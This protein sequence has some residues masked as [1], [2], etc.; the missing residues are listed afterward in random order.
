MN[1]G[2]FPRYDMNKINMNR[3]VRQIE[4]D[5][6]K[7]LKAYHDT[8]GLLTV[9]IGHLIKKTDPPAICEL[10]LGDAITEDQCRELL[11]NDLAIAISDF[12][13]IF[14]NW[15]TMPAEAQEILI[16]MLFN[17]GRDR[18]LKF[19]KLIAAVYASDWKE[20]AIQMEDSRWYRQVGT[21][22]KRLVSRMRTIDD[23]ASGA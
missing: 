1:K 22:A 11:N 19:K 7:K 2:W 12:R 21:R 20:A 9:G 18:F 17:L 14:N 8:E 6:G 23:L 13:V 16:N 3:L 4:I 15:E 5:E 10:K